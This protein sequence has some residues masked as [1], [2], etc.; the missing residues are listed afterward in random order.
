[1]ASRD[2]GSG[3]RDADA[4]GPM[5]VGGGLH[6]KGRGEAGG[7]GWGEDDGGGAAAERGR[8]GRATR[9]PGC[10]AAA[11]RGGDSD[12]YGGW[13]KKCNLALYHVGN[14]NL[15]LGLGICINRLELVGQG[16]LQRGERVIT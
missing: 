12:D 15:G 5:G 7:V 3:G 1:M 10:G 16:P 6:G 11:G 14:P 2:G 8:A 9:T 13:R 4:R